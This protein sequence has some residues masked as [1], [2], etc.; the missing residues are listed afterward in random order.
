MKRDRIGL[1]LQ[2]KDHTWDKEDWFVPLAA[3]LDGVGA[4]EAAWR[5]PGGGNTIWQTVNHVNYYNERVLSRL[6]GS[7]SGPS[8]ENNDTTFGDPGDPRDTAGWQAALE[9]TRHVA[10]GLRQALSERTDADLD[11]PRAASN[12]T[13]LGELLAAWV[14]HDAYH[15]GQIVL[16]RK[17]Q[18][19][20]PAR[21]G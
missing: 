15:T 19:S 10:E 6:T 11:Q 1:L 14:M 8:A 20:W 3:A 5:P 17:Q 2:Q 7:P 12:S 4:A 18:G 16:I 21:R 9:R 13:P